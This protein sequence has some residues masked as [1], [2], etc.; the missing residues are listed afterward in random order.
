MP[1]MFFTVR[2]PDGETTR[3][4][5]PSLVVANHL[6]PGASYELPDFVERATG[7]LAIASD[8]VEARYGFPCG[9]AR[10]AS[11]AIRDRAQSMPAD[12]HDALV[13]IISFERIVSG[14]GIAPG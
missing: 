12:R 7:A 14:E 1:E 6:E 8:R 11:A 9:R 10:A 13:T 2:W 5:S 3:S 4:Y